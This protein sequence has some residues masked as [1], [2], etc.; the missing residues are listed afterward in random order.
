MFIIIIMDHHRHHFYLTFVFVF[1]YIEY[2][3]IRNNVWKKSTISLCENCHVYWGKKEKK[4]SSSFSL[5]WKYKDKKEIGLSI[6]SLEEEENKRLNSKQKIRFM[7]I[8]NNDNANCLCKFHYLN[9]KFLCIF[10]NNKKIHSV[11]F[12]FI[13]CQFNIFDQNTQT[14]HY[15][16]FSFRYRKK[17]GKRNPIMIHHYW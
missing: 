8:M 10:F 14:D 12:L 15:P 17:A 6:I 3:I 5:I 2:W 16:S 1:F 9:V 4:N 11:T 7:I 13:I